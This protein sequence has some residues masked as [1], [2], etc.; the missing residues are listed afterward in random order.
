MEYIPGIYKDILNF[1][2][3]MNKR[4]GKSTGREPEFILQD[5]T[6]LMRHSKNYP[7]DIDKRIG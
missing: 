2:Y 1:S 3:A 7:G 5:E 6:V 4:M